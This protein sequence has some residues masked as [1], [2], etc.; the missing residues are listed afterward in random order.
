[1]EIARNKKAEQILF[2]FDKD[3][4]SMKALN[5]AMRKTE[6]WKYNQEGKAGELNRGLY[7]SMAQL[8]NLIKTTY[9]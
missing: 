9:K 5:E 3:F 4:A 6:L 7:D 8:A 1:M 2:R